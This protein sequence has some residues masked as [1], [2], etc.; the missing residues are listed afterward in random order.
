ME[1]RKAKTKTDW[2]E[3]KQTDDMYTN[4]ENR[5]FRI[6]DDD[7]YGQFREDLVNKQDFEWGFEVCNDNECL[8][9][10]PNQPFSTRNKDVWMGFYDA[11]EKKTGANLA[12]YDPT[13]WTP[14]ITRAQAEPL[15]EKHLL[16][17]KLWIII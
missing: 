2:Y 11:V 14:A 10:E 13:V 1:V 9:G 12:M 5:Q 16:I 4:L 3:Q 8:F 6:V 15:Q 17:N 7:L